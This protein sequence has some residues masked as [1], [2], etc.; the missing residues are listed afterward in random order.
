MHTDL[1]LLVLF[2]SGLCI[3]VLSFVFSVGAPLCLRSTGLGAELSKLLFMV[4]DQDCESLFA[5]V[6]CCFV[7]NV[8][9]L[10]VPRDALILIPSYTSEL[11]RQSNI[12]P[13]TVK[14]MME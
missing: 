8:L 2:L 12:I 14:R 5:T 11:S 1:L 3:T 13:K 6:F 7:S 10:Q 9:L 4:E